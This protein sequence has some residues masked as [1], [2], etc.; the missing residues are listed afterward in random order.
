MIYLLRMCMKYLLIDF[1][2]TYIKCAVYNKTQDQ[3]VKGQIIPSPFFKVNK[4]SKVELLNILFNIVSLHEK[5]DGIIICTILGGSYVENIYYSWKSFQSN[6][7][8]KCMISGLFNAKPHIHHSPFTNSSEYS[9]KLEILGNILST[10]I[11]SSLGDTDCVIKSINLAQ[12]SVAIN[13]GTGSQIITLNKIERYFPSGRMFLT[14]QELFQSIGINMFKLMDNIQIENV[15][16]SSL[17]LNLNVFKQSR[18]YNFGGSISNI[19][20]GSFNIQ[21][22]LGS[23][24]KEFVLQY[25]SFIPEFSEILLL[26]GISKKISIL[27]DL[28][29]IYY[30]KSTVILLEDDI[31]ST[32]KGMIKYIKEEL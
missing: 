15:I 9:N 25:K 14:F 18:N 23:I 21:N 22:L 19:N 26:G 8:D 4:I 31:E 11:Y 16:H 24:L 6:K 28:F 29:K 10:P 3:Y 20:E 2:A 7:G 13:M 27:P 12:N 32:H 1:G 17:N 30:P 5:V